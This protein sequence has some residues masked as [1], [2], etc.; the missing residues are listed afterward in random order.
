MT[1]LQGVDSMIGITGSFRPSR[2]VVLIALT[3][4]AA[5]TVSPSI[6]LC[7]DW[8][9]RTI[10]IIVPFA[11]G[12]G[13]DLAAR[14]IA[15]PLSE[16]LKVP[17]IVQN[18]G[19]GGGNIGI[20]AASRATPDGY[21]LLTVSTAFEVNA[22]LYEKAGYD[23]IKDFIP[24]VNIGA[25]PDVLVV[26][27]ASRFKDFGEFIA[28]A[29]ANPGKLNWAAPAVGTTPYLA[30]ERLK[31]EMGID[32]VHIP[33]AGAG[34][35]SQAALAGQLD[36]YAA[37]IG[38]VLG[39]IKAG[40]LRP[41]AQTG[42]TRWPDLPNVPRLEDVGLRAFVS[43]T[44]QSMYL[45]A[46]TPQEIVDR[47]AKEVQAILRRPELKERFLTTGLAVVNE[48]PSEFKTR[49]VDEVTM[50]KNIIDKIGL[51]IR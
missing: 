38:S 41:I 24:L 47:L 45:P 17:V 46:G 8:P 23:P 28:Y 7:A 30:V 36:M 21:T 42:S 3:A 26:P 16:V 18:R 15:Q 13:S 2:R 1:T 22:S 43:E 31:F 29:K 35:A 9:T 27:A 40:T 5:A 6:A 37:N 20:V 11:A 33:F 25:A 39:Q 48:G 14:M 19:G 12:G 44:H 51:K 10:T 49:V 4:F 32:M 34:P 50:Y